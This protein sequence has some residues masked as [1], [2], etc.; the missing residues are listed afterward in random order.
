MKVVSTFHPS[1]SVVS[2]L[3]CTLATKDLEHLVVAKL[4]R[5][6]VYSVNAHGLEHDCGLDIWGKICSVKALPHSE[7]EV[8]SNIIVMITH[9]EPELLI[10]KYSKDGDGI[11]HLE[12]A[13]SIPLFER[14]PRVAEF[15]NNVLVHPSG[16]QA[17]VSCYA[18]KLKVIT[19][20]G[21]EYVSDFDATIPEINIFSIAY[22]PVQEDDK[23]AIAI[24]HFDSQERLQLCARDIDVD[25]LEIPRQL[26]TLLAPTIVTTNY[27]VYPTDTPLHLIPVRP[28]LDA[29]APEGTFLG[30]ILLV[31]GDRL[32][33]Y[34]LA[35][36]EDQ[37]KQS[38]KQRRLETKKKGDSSEAAKAKAKEQERASRKRKPKATLEW[39]WS[40]VSAWTSV[41]GA[42][43]RFLLG[44]SFG[45]LSLLSVENVNELGMILIPLGETSPATTISY[46]T[47]Q[48]VYLGSH[49]GDS[50]LL[51]ISESP[52]SSEDVP[53][54]T[55]PAGFQAV[56]SGS[57][58]SVASK[59]G[60][61]KA[62]AQE[63]DMDVDDDTSTKSYSRG[64]V[65][66]SRKSFVTVLDTYKNIAPIMDAILVDTDN[67]KQH[68]I[69]TCS[70]GANTGSINVIRSGAE[71]KELASI[72]GIVNVTGVWTV[73][74][75]PDARYDTHMIVSMANETHLFEIDNVNGKTTLKRIG[76]SALGGLV[77]SQRTL[78]FAPFSLR[79]HG[80]YKPSSLVVQVVATGVHLLEWDPTMLTYVERASWDVKTVLQAHNR[81]T[82]IAA[83]SINFSQI[84]LA[85][86][87]GNVTLLCLEIGA[88]QFRHVMTHSTGSE[89]SAIS[90][91]P[92]EPEQQ[93][94]SFL[95]V[96][97]WS[98]NVVEVFTI[99]SNGFTSAAERRSPPLPAVVRSILLHSFS[100]KEKD[101]TYLLAGLG[102]GS[103]ASLHWKRGAT[104]KDRQLTDLKVVSL[105]HAPV[106]LT[107]CEV[108]G[109]RC[110]FAAGNKATVF[111]IDNGRLANSA[112]TLKEISGASRL[113]TSAFPDSLILAAP[114]GLFIGSIGD[115]KKM[116]I[117][118]AS[119]GLKNPRRIA[120]SKFLKAFG[121]ASVQSLPGRVGDLDIGRSTFELL[122]D[123]ALTSLAEYTCEENEEVTSL[124][125]FTGTENGEEKP[126]FC[127]GT[128]IFNP[129]EKEPSAGKLHVFTAYSGN[130]GRKST[131]ELSLVASAEVKGCVFALQSVDGKIAAAVNSSILLYEFIAAST[132]EE[133]EVARLDKVAEW[134]HNYLVTSLS[135]YDN[136][137][138]AGDQISSI[139]LLKVDGNRLVSVARDYGPLY[140]LAVEA[141]N[142]KNVIAS[143]DS[144][145]LVLFSLVKNIRGKVLEN[146]GSYHIAEL[147]SKF[148]RG[149]VNFGNKTKSSID[150]KFEP[151]MF[152]FTSSGKIGVISDVEDIQLSLH[153]T[154]LQR[155]L[156]AAIP[157]VGGTSHTRFRAPKNTRGT[158]DADSS[159][160]GFVDGDFLEQFLNV[161]SP[162]TLSKVLKGSSAPEEL[163]LSSDE[164]AK[165]L[166]DL[167]SSH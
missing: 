63:D 34:E 159:A 20:S 122:D 129:E 76:A 70:G 136:Y 90:I 77:T 31:G 13:K 44:D 158:S 142:E 15:F 92:S 9:P 113:N 41:E 166:Q 126:F 162:E 50:Q 104:W 7:Y 57:L 154:E 5:I 106:S 123:V 25:G 6:D 132:G 145:N 73:K 108:G 102:D 133:P 74:S 22:L 42:P 143:S 68:Q 28:D 118:S 127:L 14:L 59:K 147:V 1:S 8:R 61:G 119:L 112:I 69:V 109:Q 19:F 58:T 111:F 95:S 71:F 134:N 30:G 138:A 33:L 148:I 12:L 49:F 137:I 83:A 56:S 16:K 88:K 155:N 161:Q 48:C 79:D 66:D 39:P 116:N 67:S 153:L 150:S 36:K 165:I 86:S 64:R 32:A 163:K 87:G 80:G 98:S 117:R 82:E 107:P 125:S 144:L 62:P 156:A 110:V 151:E 89:I 100:G 75:T 146:V 37:R 55:F 72:P 139:S 120:Y 115:L 99:S 3:K 60:K 40:A 85:L 124:V 103:V 128:M 29:D 157:G 11:A 84:A 94:S 23:F 27:V 17:I 160:R 52:V 152:F 18:T 46:L 47:N 135:S 2:S 26:S 140:P 45:R 105:G 21:G 91:L 130:V 38:D 65:V 51:K 121:V 131:L 96:S 114:H 35:S 167:Q 101:E 141:L 43:F 164:F 54:L 81:P 10:L 149:S 24:L 97:Y 78:I 93:Y 4:N 53:A